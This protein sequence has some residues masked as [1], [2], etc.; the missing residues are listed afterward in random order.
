MNEFFQENKR[1][2][3]ILVAALFVLAAVLFFFLVNPLLSDLKSTK[4]NIDSKETDI[5]LLEAQLANIGREEVDIDE[6]TLANEK[7]IPRERHLDEYI[8]SLQQLELLNNSKIE[9]VAFAYDS[10]MDLEEAEEGAETPE[11]HIEEEEADNEE[12]EESEATENGEEE[13]IDEESEDGTP[14]IDP[15]ILQEKPDQLQVMT[16]SMTGRSQS[17]NDFL[18][19]IEMIEDME[20]I[21]IVTNVHFTQPVEEDEFIEDPMNTVPFQAEITTFYY[22]K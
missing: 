5:E 7:K 14:T 20:R 18:A 16:V 12:N 2:L 3:L 9:S 17:Y 22:T 1:A 13:A 6:E 11:E 8:L 10:S 4:A 19:L 21:S 15:V